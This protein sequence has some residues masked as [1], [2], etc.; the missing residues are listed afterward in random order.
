MV[1]EDCS[2]CRS[3]KAGQEKYLLQSTEIFSILNKIEI[4]VFAEEIHGLESLDRLKECL[5]KTE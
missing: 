5:F 2:F 4:P 1:S 3:R